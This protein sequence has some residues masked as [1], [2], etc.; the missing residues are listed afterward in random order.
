MDVANATE[1]QLEADE[2]L[3]MRILIAEDHKVIRCGIRGIL[4]RR[5]EWEICGE[6]VNGLEAVRLAKKLRPD[7]IIM[8]IGMPIM[9][10]LEATRQVIKDDRDSKVLILTMHEAESLVETARR[11]GACGYLVK[12][13]A[14]GNLIKALERVHSGGTFFGSIGTD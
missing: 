9:N 7:I 5:P 8:D 6:A 13:Q 2:N 12:S 14:G 3:L 1:T 11:V 10:G 4:T